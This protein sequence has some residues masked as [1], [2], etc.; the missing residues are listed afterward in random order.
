MGLTVSQLARHAGVSVRTLH[1]Y[2]EIGLLRPSSRGHAG[3]R[4]Y[5]ARDL[6][7]LQQILFFKE[8]GFPLDEVGRL[9]DDRGFD[10][11]SALQLQRQLLQQRAERTTQLLGAID[12]A[13]SALAQGHTMTPDEMFSVFGQDDPTRHDPEAQ[14]RWGQTDAYQE[15]RRR[16]AGYGPSDWSAMKAEAEAI[17]AD[18]AALAA[19]GA[20]ADGEAARAIAERHRKHIARWFY[21]CA[22]AMHRALGEMYVA[23]PRFTA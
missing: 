19:T 11:R 2:D 14:Q 10:L 5:E 1:H 18:L 17:V 8:L 15:S 13:L 9:L 20:P 12:R 6:V 4:R 7:R 22:P 3:Y 23:D 16:T 21:P